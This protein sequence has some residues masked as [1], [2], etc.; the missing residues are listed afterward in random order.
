MG[1][2]TLSLVT[3]LIRKRELS[4]CLEA[5]RARRD[6]LQNL[7]IRVDCAAGR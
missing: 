2:L 3:I 6:G 4:P 5:L 1:Q 7:H